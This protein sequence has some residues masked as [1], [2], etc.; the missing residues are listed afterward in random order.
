MRWYDS[1]ASSPGRSRE[2]N[3]ITGVSHLLTMLPSAVMLPRSPTHDLLEIDS[4]Y[5]LLP[6]IVFLC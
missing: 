4:C 6:G 3:T 1:D 5:A 2:R